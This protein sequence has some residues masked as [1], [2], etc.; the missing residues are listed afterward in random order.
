MNPRVML[1]GYDRE[2]VLKIQMRDLRV[3]GET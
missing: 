1:T 2:A 3:S